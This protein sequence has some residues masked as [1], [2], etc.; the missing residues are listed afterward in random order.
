MTGPFSGYNDYDGNDTLNGYAG[1][2]TLYGG[3]QDDTLYGGD[4]DDTL[5]GGL[6]PIYSGND[7]LSGEYGNDLLDSGA[8]DDSLVGGFGNDTLTGGAGRDSFVFNSSSEGVDTITDFSVADDMLEVSKSGFGGVKL[9]A[10]AFLS[11]K[12]F[13]PGAA[14]HDRTD[15]FIYNQGTGAL[16]FD[17]D[18]SKGG[19]AQVQIAQLSAGLSLS[20]RD[21]YVTA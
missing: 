4:D 2:D 21:I 3:N 11:S 17:A 20:H 8:G 15:R 7:Y 6:N 1:N 18:G 10:D 5:Y 16:Y 9:R 13:Y 19:F 12:R 14:A